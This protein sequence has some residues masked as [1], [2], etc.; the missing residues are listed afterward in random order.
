MIRFPEFNAAAAMRLVAAAAFAFASFVASP[1][2]AETPA[3]T[4]TQLH[5]AFVGDSMADGLWGAMFRRLGKDKCLAERIKL[6]RKARNGTGLTRLDQFNWVD[7]IGKIVE[8]FH[9]DLTVGS[10]GINDRQGIVEKDRRAVAYPSAAFDTRYTELVADV[11]RADANADALAKNKIFETAIKEVGS[12]KATYVQ[13]WTSGANPDVYKPYL[14]NARNRMEMVRAPDGIHFTRAG[15]DMVMDAIFP[16][17]LASL[18]AR[19]RDLE[20]E[21]PPNVGAR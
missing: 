20:A 12:D 8:D 15:Y 1:A 4:P 14:P 3:P 5:V 19:G 10:F 11:V 6:L 18:K 21:C 7:E 17:I 13:P 9:P 2:R 16:S